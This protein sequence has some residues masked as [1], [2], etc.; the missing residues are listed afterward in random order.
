VPGN[1]G[2]GGLSADHSS[3]DL[4]PQ[5]WTHR[6]P[7]CSGLRGFQLVGVVRPDRCVGGWHCRLHPFGDR[8]ESDEQ[9]V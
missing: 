8:F 6:G 2:E 3:S 7:S 5:A 9:L 4:E 1:G